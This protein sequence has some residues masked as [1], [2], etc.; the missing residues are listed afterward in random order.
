VLGAKISDVDKV[1]I[2]SNNARRILRAACAVTSR[3]AS[4]IKKRPLGELEGFLRGTRF[5][6]HG[7]R[8]DCFPQGALIFPF[9]GDPS[10][11]FVQKEGKWLLERNEK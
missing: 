11:S 7:G 3:P 6:I 1:K 10:W 5:L 9:I 2:L 8:I 4:L